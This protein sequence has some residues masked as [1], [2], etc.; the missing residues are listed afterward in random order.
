MYQVKKSSMQ[1][2]IY[3]KSFLG[4]NTTHPDH[5]MVPNLDEDK[6]DTVLA[7]VGIND[8]LKGANNDN[9]I[10]W[11]ARIG[12]PCK[13]YVVKSI[14]ISG[15]I[16]MKRIKKEIVNMINNKLENFCTHIDSPFLH[17]VNIRIKHLCKDGLY[18]NE[19]DKKVLYKNI[20]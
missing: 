1:Q 4:A 7:H 3:R 5:H 9:L 17:D 10:I 8:V 18:L 11:I 15:L 19:N 16:Y 2:Q 13:R 14:V 12:N 6:P 20:F